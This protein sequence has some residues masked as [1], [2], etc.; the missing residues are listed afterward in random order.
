MQLVKSI[1]EKKS[2]EYSRFYRLYRTKILE[3]YKS[4]TKDFEKYSI[5][6]SGEVKIN[7]HLDDRVYFNDLSLEEKEMIFDKLV[8][9]LSKMMYIRK[10]NY[11]AGKIVLTFKLCEYNSVC[12]EKVL[13]LRKKILGKRMREEDENHE[14]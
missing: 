8:D 7:D 5:V 9:D 6:I 11:G 13:K 12:K 10:S 3:K 4:L 2:A 14:E 1:S